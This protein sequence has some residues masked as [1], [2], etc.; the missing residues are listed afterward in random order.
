MRKKMM[1]AL[2]VVCWSSANTIA[3]DV[4]TVTAKG[5]AA[6]V[7]GNV[8]GA[9]KAALDDARRSA[10]EQVGSEIISETVVENFELVKDVIVTKVAGYIKDYKVMSQ[11]CSA[12]SCETTIEAQVSARQIKDDAT[13]IYNEMDKPR[14]MILIPETS[15]SGEVEIKSNVCEN[16]VMEYFK[17][18][19]FELVDR[20][21]ALANIEAD[22]LRAAAR[23]DERTAV[24]LGSRAGAEVIV[25]GT[26]NT[27]VPESI[28]GILYASTPTISVRALNTANAGVYATSSEV[29]KGQG[30]TPDQAQKT[31]LQQT[32]AVVGK[33]I[34]WKIV[35]AWNTEKLNGVPV[36][37]VVTGVNF[38]KLNKL[39]KDLAQF[40]EVKEVIQREFAAPTATLTVYVL[41]DANRLAELIDAHKIA[42]VS[43]V[44]PGKITIKVR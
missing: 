10:V 40:K 27:G 1:I 8:E 6:V 19:G 24:M 31:A 14:I 38:S 15:P 25:V 28:R 17:S 23:G 7:S 21:Q 9:R 12:A 4:V 29:G 2:M 34:F 32:A 43:S 30:G 16:T 11:S 3:Q 26:A 35:Q 44:S 20:N 37:V 5:H 22:K 18:K 39:K 33:D 42:E 13:I 41:G 36:E